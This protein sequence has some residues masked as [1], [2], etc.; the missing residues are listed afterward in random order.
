[1]HVYDAEKFYGLE[2][3]I[4]DSKAVITAQV[5][6]PKNSKFNYV[7]NL[8]KLIK[9]LNESKAENITSIKDLLG[10]DQPDLSLIVSVL[11][12]AGWNLNDDIFL[13]AE[14]WQAR[15]TPKHKPMNDSHKQNIILGHIVDS[16]AVDKEGNEIVV[17]NEDELPDEFDLEVAGV[18]YSALPELA[19]KIASIMEKAEEGSMFVSMEVWFTDFGYGVINDDGST[20]IIDRDES[21]AFLTKHLKSFGGTGEVD[22]KKIG[23]VLKNMI[24]AGQ[25][26]TTN[27]ANLESV[28]RTAAGETMNKLEGG[29]DVSAEDLQ[30]RVDELNA[31]IKELDET[32]ANKDETIKDLENKLSEANESNKN[33]KEESDKNTVIAEEVENTKKSL[34]EV[35][36]ERDTL[37]TTVADLEKT[38][39]K[40]SDEL[41]DIR[42]TEVAKE[43]LV[44]LSEFKDIDN[45][46]EAIAELKTMTD[47]TF[48]VVLKY[49]SVNTKEKFETEDNKNDKATAAL[50]T[51]KEDKDDPDMIVSDNGESE[52]QEDYM[53]LAYILTGHNIEDKNGD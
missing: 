25:A 26:F 20:K 16:K 52:E 31:K 21:T 15:H 36:K 28:I 14:L 40:L 47:E 12:S 17:D 44:K 24:F 19:P 10:M 37:K 45:E 41:E 53:S 13:P 2:N 23:R 46:E 34:D 43:R 48:D 30:K 6:I 33:L 8:D 32:M 18:L 38:N 11:V 35:C 51:A 22:G 1:M 42:K 7:Q 27:P 50:D 39:K 49:A 9:A 3:K 5:K 4:N 29:A